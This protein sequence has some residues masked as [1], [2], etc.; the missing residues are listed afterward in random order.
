MKEGNEAVN[1]SI[2]TP[3]AAAISSFVRNNR[4]RGRRNLSELTENLWVSYLRRKGVKLPPLFKESGNG[5]A[6]A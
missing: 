3:I 1:L 2:S 5:R 4:R 6:A